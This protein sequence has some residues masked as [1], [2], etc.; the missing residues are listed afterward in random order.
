MLY[1]SRM[2][3]LRYYCLKFQFVLAGFAENI[4]FVES[5][6]LSLNYSNVSYKRKGP[7]FLKVHI[8][9]GSTR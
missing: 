9:Q 8:Q 1:E 6:H 2:V 5:F 3:S 7:R 4:N